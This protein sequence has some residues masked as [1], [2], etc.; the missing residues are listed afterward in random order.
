[1]LL[2]G[3]RVVDGD[4]QPLAG[5]A[6]RGG[7]SDAGGRPRHQ[8]DF[9]WGVA[10]GLTSGCL[11]P[12]ARRGPSVPPLLCTARWGRVP[13]SP[14]DQ[15]RPTEVYVMS[16]MP[17]VPA[18][19]AVSGAVT[20]PTSRKGRGRGFRPSTTDMPWV[21]S[22][23]ASGPTSGKRLLTGTAPSASVQGRGTELEQLHGVQ[24]PTH[25]GLGPPPQ[26]MTHLLQQNL[27]KLLARPVQ[28]DPDV[29]RREGPTQARGQLF[30]HAGRRHL[31]VLDVEEQHR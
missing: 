16:A 19:L 20:R 4:G 25:L 2:A 6:D 23:S 13:P 11:A 18:G 17:G 29:N 7:A 15:G 24:F 1:G 31:W 27:G 28:R 12:K 8:G 26:G 5:E 30:R 14:R 9:P 22:G 10:H 21:L 3:A